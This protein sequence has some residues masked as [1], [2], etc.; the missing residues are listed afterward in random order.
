M[1]VYVVPSEFCDAACEVCI[2]RLREPH[3]RFMDAGR[4]EGV[5]VNVGE[6]ERIE[7]TGGGE[8]TLNPQIG[9]IIRVCA[10][11]QEDVKTYTHG[12]HLKGVE[13]LGLLKE[14]CVSVAH[15]DP[16]ENER[17]IGVVT[18]LDFLGNWRGRKKFSL[19]LQ[20]GG[21]YNAEGLREYLNWAKSLASKVVVRQLFEECL[22]KFSDRFVSCREVYE[23]FG[24]RGEVSESGM[25]VKFGD[26]DVEF[27]YRACGCDFKGIVL[28]PDCKVRYGWDGP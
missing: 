28:R 16:V 15:Y 12:A 6:I 1:K 13:N 21:I 20:K 9:E 10:S 11:K 2:S 17:L 19:L 22:D 25:N 18:D 4:L 27:E 8:P 3:G 7:I 14:L 23:E 24:L 26:L 5:L